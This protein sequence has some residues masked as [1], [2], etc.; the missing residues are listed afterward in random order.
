MTIRVKV[1]PRSAKSEFAGEMQDGT[2][3]IRVTAPPDKG[4]ANQEVCALL[5][6]K[7]G[8]P[9]CPHAGGVGLCEYAQH[10]S[11]FDYVAVGASLDDRVCEF[12]DH[13]HEHFVDPVR[14]VDGHYQV[15]TAPGYSIEIRPES[16]AEFAFPDGPGW[17]GV[18]EQYERGGMT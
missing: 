1:I 15:P 10:L 17:W 13:L 18:T 7:F 2:L 12:V 11:M 16:L 4:L 8:V 9:V 6:A 14:V 5:A 3:K